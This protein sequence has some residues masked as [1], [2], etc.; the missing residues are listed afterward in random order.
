MA[1]I[2]KKL[3]LLLFA[4]SCAF[5][6]FSAEDNL[7]LR[8]FP[9]LGCAA[10]RTGL[11][12]REEYLSDKQQHNSGKVVH[13]APHSQK[14][15]NEGLLGVLVKNCAEATVIP[16]V[17]EYKICNYKYH[18]RQRKGAQRKN[19]AF[20]SHFFLLIKIFHTLYH[21][22]QKNNR[23]NL[24]LLK[25]FAV[26]GMF[27]MVILY[28]GTAGH[29]CGQEEATVFCKSLTVLTPFVKKYI[30]LYRILNAFRGSNILHYFIACAR[31]LYCKGDTPV[32]FLKVREK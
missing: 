20:L 26:S 9:F 12:L 31:F 28:Y 23:G 8:T 22:V 13:Y 15:R 16:H 25:F 3:F 10:V 18:H 7:F 5:V 4:V 14:K 17:V 24:P 29:E 1:Y 30:L 19:I 21:V 2:A 27:S 11:A 6:S 32:S